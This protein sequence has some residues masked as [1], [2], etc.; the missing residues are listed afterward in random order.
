MKKKKLFSVLLAGA[1]VLSMAGCGGSE[2]GSGGESGNT[3][4]AGS[5]E[6]DSASADTGADSSSAA[7]SGEV[8]EIRFTEWDGGD[9]LAVYEEVAENFNASHPG[10]HV[11]VMNIPDEYDT[12]IT[13]MIAGN[14]TPE[15]CMLNSDTLLFPLAEEGIVANLQEYIDKDA[16]FD[17]ECV[18]DQFKYM[19]SAD[20]MAGYGIGSENITMFY[21]PSLFAKYGVEEP[22]ASYADA[23][24]WDTFVENAQKLTIDKN[25]KNALDPDFDPENIDIY[26]VT[27]SKWWAGFMPFLLSQG[28]DY[29]TEDGSAIGYATPEGKDVLQKLADLTYV[30]HVAPTPTTS[31]TMPGL[32]EALATGKVAMS[33]D[34]QWSNATLMSDGVEYNVAAL[35]RMGDKAQT[36]ATFGSIALMNT[37]K[38]DAAFEFIKYMLTE[39]GACEPLFLSGLWLPTNMKEYNDDYIKSVITDKHP[40]NYY[41]TIVK[42][43]MDG[44]ANTPITAYVKNFN[45][46]ND[47]ISPALDDLW[48][49]ERTAEEAISSIE[50]DANAQVQGFYGK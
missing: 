29:L 22:P 5:S 32:S 43:M 50:A 10:I 47:I 25:G 28:G 16:E 42:P 31:Q 46:I 34:G 41:E 11:T 39:V 30:Y 6:S 18:G 1:M 33:F 44:T 14:D 26:G 4:D 21:N 20:Y 3:S 17:K 8:V 12:K 49:G 7:D 36:V 19:L 48:S 37:E 27:I 15:V 35:P 24:D 13:A 38:A 2:S 9:T 45:K 23:W 40:A